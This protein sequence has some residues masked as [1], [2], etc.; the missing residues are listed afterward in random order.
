MWEINHVTYR[1]RVSATTIYTPCLKKGTLKKGTLI[2]TASI[3]RS[4][5]RR[6]IYSESDFEGFRPAGVTRCTDEGEIGAEEWTEG[7]L[8]HAKFHPIGATIRV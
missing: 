2:I 3:A 1:L 5:K 6:Y 4:A 8:L 7:S